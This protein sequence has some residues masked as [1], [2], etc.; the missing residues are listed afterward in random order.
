MI[1]CK[2]KTDLKESKMGKVIVFDIHDKRHMKKKSQVVGG[3]HSITFIIWEG[4]HECTFV[5][6]FDRK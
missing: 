2:V 6:I 3:L 1:D 5:D 4:L